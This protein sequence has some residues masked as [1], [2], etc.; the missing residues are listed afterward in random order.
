MISNLN[1]KYRQMVTNL[2]KPPEVLKEDWSA[3]ECH[4][5]HMLIGLCGE[6]QELVVAVENNDRCNILEELGD[7]DFYLDGMKLAFNL[8]TDV[9]RP[10]PNFDY[11]CYTLQESVAI[12][13]NDLMG[14]NGLLNV[15]KRHIISRKSSVTREEVITAI[16]NLEAQFANL[17]ISLCYE[18]AQCREHNY[19]KLGQRYSSGMYS[20]DQ[21]NNREDKNEDVSI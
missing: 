6:L 19:V 21:A 11:D 3:N 5:L 20:D 8:P 2:I 13:Q 15:V 9:V 4:V 12:F 17:V 14:D 7:I 10:D 16:A 1:R 18:R